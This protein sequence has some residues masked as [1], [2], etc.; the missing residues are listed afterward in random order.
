MKANGKNMMTYIQTCVISTELMVKDGRLLVFN[1][2]AFY[3]YSDFNNY[4]HTDIQ[5]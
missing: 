4:I 1:S 2:F 3:F 5:I